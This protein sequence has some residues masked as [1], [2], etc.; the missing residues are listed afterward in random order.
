MRAALRRPQHEARCLSN[1][2]KVI[3]EAPDVVLKLSGRV[4]SGDW[5]PAGVGGSHDDS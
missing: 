1:P 4:E 3:D 5:I 2:L